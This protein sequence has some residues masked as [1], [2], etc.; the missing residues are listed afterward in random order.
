M[1]AARRS[2][3]KFSATS[4]L[5][6]P[7]VVSELKR[8]WLDSKPDASG[9]HE[10]GGFIVADDEDRLSVIRWATGTQ[11]EI[12]LPPHRNCFAEGKAIVASFHT[13]PN[14]GAQ[15][16]QEPSLTDVRAVRD[17]PDLKGEF[18]FGEFVI[19]Q[20]NIYLIEPSGAFSAIAETSEVFQGA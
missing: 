1:R 8:A 11:S 20:Q 16:E 3:M 15:F 4:L 12:T 10:K 2:E 13:H 14:T 5:Q 6:T 7:A 19:S 17:D 18:Y 9:G